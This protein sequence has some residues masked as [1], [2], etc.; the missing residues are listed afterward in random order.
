MLD[1]PEVL[2]GA[3]AGVDP[4]S[5]APPV[6]VPLDDVP[7]GGTLLDIRPEVEGAGAKLTPFGAGGKSGSHVPRLTVTWAAAPSG[8][9]RYRASTHKGCTMLWSLR[10]LQN[11]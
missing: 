2:L 6:A 3:I 8:D 9:D 5:D 7:L 10:Q 4:G 1:S 11:A